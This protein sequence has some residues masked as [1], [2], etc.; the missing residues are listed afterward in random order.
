M[1]I[2]F[3]HESLGWYGS[4]CSPY[5]NVCSIP[6]WLLVL[7]RLSSYFINLQWFSKIFM[8][9]Q[10]FRPLASCP[11]R[12][13][14][15]FQSFLQISIDIHWFT[16]ISWTSNIYA[17]GRNNSP[18]LIG[19][20]P[21][22]NLRTGISDIFSLHFCLSL[23]ASA[24]AEATRIGITKTMDQDMYQ[25]HVAMYISNCGNFIQTLG[26]TERVSSPRAL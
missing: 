23:R 20:R 16:W 3:W 9:F 10:G 21:E 24:R 6:G 18:T 25:K 19:F 26:T 17:S 15:V 2:D 5:K 8:D 22:F 7:W 11:L 14:I 12:T 1:F 13:F 4:T